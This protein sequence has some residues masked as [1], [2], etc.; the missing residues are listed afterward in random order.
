M[1]DRKP[2]VVVVGAGFGCRVHVP[3]ARLAGFDVV[4]VVGRDR[5]RTARRAARAGVETVCTSLADALALPRADA[6][7]VAT[8][9]ATH[10][11]LAGE[12]IAAGR[13]VLVEKPFTRTAE[14]AHRLVRRAEAAGVAALV[15]HEFRFHPGR[16]TLAGALRDGRIGPPRAAT[17]VQQS[18]FVAPTDIRMPDWWFDPDDGGGWLGAAASH[19]LDAVRVWLG[20]FASVSASLPVVSDRDPAT[21]AEDTVHARFRMTSGCE[22]VF[23]QSAGTWGE[24]VEL[25]RVAGPHGTLSLSG[26]EVTLADGQGTRPVDP[27]GPGLPVEPGPSD[28]PGHAFTHLEL[29]PA[30]IQAGIFRDLVLGRSPAY[31]AVPAATFTDGL[32]TVEVM[33]AMRRSAAA[34]GARVQ[35]PP[36][37]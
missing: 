35:V 25:T 27:Y 17:F 16:V 24:S 5:D 7:V 26:D 19:V 2:G 6:V 14:E 36:V 33:E 11:E 10:E 37:G 13:H 15:G 3:A 28:A 12:A 23:S 18:S 31:D 9:P 21:T 8:P 22:A 20:D 34:D 4:A 29:G 30:T 1:N 32:A